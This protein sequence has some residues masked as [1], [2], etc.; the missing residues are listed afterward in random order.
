MRFYSRELLA[1]KLTPNVLER[2]WPR[3][4]NWR[5][6]AAQHAGSSGRAVGEQIPA[7]RLCVPWLNLLSEV[8]RPAEEDH[9]IHHRSNP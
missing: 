9:R 7:C 5:L 2:E 3:R 6:P 4:G 1:S 8:I